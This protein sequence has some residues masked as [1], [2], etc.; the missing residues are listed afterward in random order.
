MRL[1]L[2]RRLILLGLLSLLCACSSLRATQHQGAMKQA[3]CSEAAVLYTNLKL[4]ADKRSYMLPNGVS[5]ASLTTDQPATTT[6][7]TNA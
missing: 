7:A 3:S 4:K 5:C 1:Y 2:L 6:G